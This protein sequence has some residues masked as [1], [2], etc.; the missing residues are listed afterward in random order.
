MKASTHGI[1][2]QNKETYINS[3]TLAHTFVLF[4]KKNNYS[5]CFCCVSQL[6]ILFTTARTPRRQKNEE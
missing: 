2:K 4:K 3:L 1:L 6:D 5:S